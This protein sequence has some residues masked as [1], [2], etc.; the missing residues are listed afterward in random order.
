MEDT[1]LVNPGPGYP[2]FMTPGSVAMLNLFKDSI[3][4]EFR[5][6]ER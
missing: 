6:F 4:V 1:L 2:E 3:D 5:V